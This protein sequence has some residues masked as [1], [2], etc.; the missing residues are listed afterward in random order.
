MI[1]KQ[2]LNIKVFLM[3]LGALLVML[4][5]T[6][7]EEEVPTEPVI[8]ADLGWDSAQVHNRIA[9]FILENGYGY[10]ASELVPG[11]TIPLWA[12]LGRGDVDVNM[13]CWVENQQEAYDKSI[14]AGEVVDL[15]DNFWDNWQGWLVPTYVI[16]GD[17]E[18][19]IEASA[20]DLKSVEDLPKYWELFK[21]PEDPSKGRFISCIAGWECEKINEEKFKEYG[22]DEYYNVFLPGSGAALLADMKAAYEKGEPWF[23]Y[24]WAPTP[25]LG[26][27]DM[28]PIEEPAYD[29]TVWETNHA[30]AYPAV[31]VNIIVNAAFHDKAPDKVIDF[32]TKYSTTTAQNNDALGY[33]D[34][35][36]A[37]MEE[38]AIY[39]LQKYESH[40]TEWVSDDVASK[41]KAALP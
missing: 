18:R 29:E 1:K 10:P 37:S 7:C 16:K 33:M 11:E 30:C 32:L 34:A 4:P 20:P 40:W 5:F 17:A 31:H 3:A 28:T 38:A 19:G 15:G 12:G 27:L 21:D 41:V 36:E 6:G 25:A 14:A 26:Q 13:E 9:A 2:K 24:Y 23:G 39:F 8:F 22:L 35:N